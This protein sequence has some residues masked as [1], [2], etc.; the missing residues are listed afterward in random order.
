M[1]AIVQASLTAATKQKYRGYNCAMELSQNDLIQWTATN[2]S[3]PPAP[4]YHCRRYGHP[5]VHEILVAA[6]R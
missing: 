5:I 3:A 1:Q 2:L 6:P 4:Y